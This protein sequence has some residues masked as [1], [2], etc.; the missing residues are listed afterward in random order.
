MLDKIIDTKIDTGV[1]DKNYKND[2]TGASAVPPSAL[3]KLITYGYRKGQNSSRKLEALNKHHIIAK[4]LTR[5]MRIHWTTI[6]DFISQNSGDFEE[7]FARVL[8]YCNELGL[9]GG[10]D[11][12]V[13]GDRLPSNASL[14]MTGKKKELEKRLGVY[15]RM[16]EKHIEKH[17]R[18]DE[19]GENGEATEKN[20]H[21]QQ[22]K[23][24]MRIENLDNFIK[25]MT[26]KKGGGG[27][28]ITS[29]VTDNES[30][31]IHTPKGYIQGYIGLAVADAKEQIIVSAR[32]VGSANEGEY[33]PDMLKD[34][35]GN[36][37]KA[38]VKKEPEKKPVFMADSNY[39]SEDNLKAGAGLGVEA[40]IADGSYK[41]R[42]GKKENRTYR[43]EDFTYNA[44][45]DY[46]ECPAGKKLGRTNARKI[47]GRE[48][49]LYKANADDCIVCPLKEKCSKSK[50][51]GRK[52]GRS[53]FV[54][55]S[56]SPGGLIYEHLKKLNTVEWQDKYARRI[57]IIEP[58]FA[59]ISNCKSLNR[60]TLRG[61]EKVN[62]QWLLDCMVHNL[63][64]CLK[65]YNEGK[66][67]A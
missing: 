46:Y 64:K 40:I 15:R 48:G 51:K 3:L 36:V 23:L 26:P 24:N 43:A 34:A 60:F 11:Y 13:D 12:A 53:L 42:L 7:I 56:N 59:D 67:Y 45:G 55:E 19:A 50:K 38:G 65:G 39:F 22:R 28:E 33:F 37:E 30:A 9:I 29:N 52:S 8:M 20:Y 25:N 63:G 47:S 18:R 27:N 57:Q 35:L 62:G 58:V 61:R 31:M 17:R 21:E 4:A 49:K 32:A 5:D 2:E 16:A 41:S 1:F 6:A 10:Q 44:E 54:T 14:E 66:G